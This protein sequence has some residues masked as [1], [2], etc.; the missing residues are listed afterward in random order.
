M[1]ASS[2]NDC[3]LSI[4]GSVTIL[5]ISS[6]TSPGGSSAIL[7]HEFSQFLLSRGE[8]PFFRRTV[9]FHRLLKEACHTRFSR[10]KI[11]MVAKCAIRVL[12]NCAFYSWVC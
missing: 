8:T 7:G 1:L 3:S 6:R 4:D 10:S 2:A 9:V 11:P 12:V 5:D